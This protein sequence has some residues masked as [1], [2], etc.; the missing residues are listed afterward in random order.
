MNYTMAEA[1]RDCRVGYIIARAKTENGWTVILSGDSSVQDGPLIGH[2]DK[3][4]RVFKTVDAAI[5]A[6]EE[7]VA[8]GVVS[9]GVVATEVSPGK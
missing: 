6:I 5:R 7:V 8:S 3:T 1:K 9:L 2:R 4:P